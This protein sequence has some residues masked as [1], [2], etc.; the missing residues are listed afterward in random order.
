MTVR[1]L[2]VDD[3]PIVVDGLEAVLSTQEDFVVVGSANDADSAV[4]RVRE[5]CPD[6]VLLD[7]EIPGGSGVQVLE[8]LRDEGLAARAI[9]FTAFD[10]DAR[11][12]AAVEAGARGYL[13]K[14]VA[15]ERLFEAIRTVHAGQSLLPPEL[16]SKLMQGLASK[17]RGAPLQGEHLTARELQVLRLLASGLSNPAI[18]EQLSIS[19][20]TVKFH[21]TAILAKL[22]AKSRAEAARIAAE[23]GLLGASTPTSRR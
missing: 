17:A 1:L 19:T 13:L 14:G 22:A 23:R 11:L 3:H 18:G 7:L 21:V 9:I 4:A 5:L 2:I 20:R 10:D 12:V 8:R 6:V 16:I 15:R